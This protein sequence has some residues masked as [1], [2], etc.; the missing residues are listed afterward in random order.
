MHD[1]ISRLATA[2]L[3]D[4]SSVYYIDRKT[5]HYECY[6]TNAEY[7]KLELHSWGETSLRIAKGTSAPPSMKRTGRWFGR[8]CPA[9]RS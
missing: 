8:R 5:G 4:Y 3:I 2:L 7:Q 9:N 6:S 1:H